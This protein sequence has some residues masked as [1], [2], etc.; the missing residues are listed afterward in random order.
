MVLDGVV[1][2]SGSLGAG[3]GGGGGG[4][5]DTSQARGV[6]RT[7]DAMADA[8]A[9]DPACP[10]RDD[11]GLGAAYDELAGRIEEGQALAP[12]VGPTQLAYAVFWATYDQDRWPDLWA[13]IDLGLDGD[14]SAIRDRAAAFTSL[15]PYAP[16]ALV[17]CLDSAHATSYEAWQASAAAKQT[18]SPRFGAVLAN[19]LLPCAFWPKATL[20]EL[21]VTAAG[22]API[23]VV[24][25]TGDAA[26]PYATAVE[27]ARR[28][29]SG[30]LLTVDQQG[31]VA[32]GDSDCADAAITRYLVDLTVPSPADRC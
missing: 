10:L 3:D 30:A 31:H 19:E 26:T 2:T 9:T 12:G 25:S 28:L 14:L 1:S 18:E 20:P 17:S 27:V 13:A 6:Q 15:V 24:G 5:G 11:G 23:L 22:A 8:C 21:V 16:F 29:E 4:E 7:F 32:T